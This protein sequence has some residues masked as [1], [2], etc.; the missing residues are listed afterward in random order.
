VG[1]G[2]E[3]IEGSKG[4]RRKH[5]MYYYYPKSRKAAQRYG[6]DFLVISSYSHKTKQKKT[7]KND[8]LE[9]E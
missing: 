4:R 9:K 5:T 3:D 8:P 6:N 7:E 1:K 2:R